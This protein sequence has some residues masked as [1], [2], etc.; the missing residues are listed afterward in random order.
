MK[1]DEVILE[2]DVDDTQCSEQNRGHISSSD[3]RKNRG[4]GHSISTSAIPR[5]SRCTDRHTVVEKIVKD[6]QSPAASCEGTGCEEVN[7]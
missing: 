6:S 1:V 7:Q 2:T 4:S 3:R 5:T